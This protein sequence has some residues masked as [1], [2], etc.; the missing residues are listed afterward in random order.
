MHLE[1]DFPA[2]PAGYSAAAYSEEEVET[3]VEVVAYSEQVEVVETA[4]VEVV[5]ADLEAL[6]DSLGSAETVER[7]TTTPSPT[8]S[9]LT[10][11][12]RTGAFSVDTMGTV[13]TRD[14]APRSTNRKRK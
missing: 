13:A 4:A 14:T 5:A 7:D 11:T 2:D 12:T 6:A 10:F 9:S 1:E 3:V 8:F